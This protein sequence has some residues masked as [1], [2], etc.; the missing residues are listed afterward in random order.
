MTF[1]VLGVAALLIISG[2]QGWAG[3]LKPP[4]SDPVVAASSGRTMPAVAKEPARAR[5]EREGFEPIRHTI[6]T[7]RGSARVSGAPPWMRHSNL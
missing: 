3:C 1:T 4:A 2:N 7:S 5:V 6:P